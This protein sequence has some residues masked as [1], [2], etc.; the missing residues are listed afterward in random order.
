MED[1]KKI[2]AALA[3]TEY[4]KEIFDFAED[5]SRRLNTEL[6]VASVINSR[7]VEAVG[8]IASMGYDIDG[9]HYIKNIKA[10][11]KKYFDQFLAQA[12]FNR[13]DVSLILK[14]GNPVDELLKL[15]VKENVDMVVMG[16]KGRTDI[17]H[18][19]T[20]SVASKLF[21]YSPVPIISVRD[22]KSAKRL[23]KRIKS[24]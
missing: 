10:E 17:K 6:I 5:I 19:F 14:V 11:R 18:A 13:K 4:S 16:I 20:G 9:D 15:I 3:F 24:T 2:M 12:S 1:V 22:D 7:D 23:K 21:R 8:M